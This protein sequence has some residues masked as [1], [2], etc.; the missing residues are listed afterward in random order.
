MEER[1]RC[2]E[3]MK[4]NKLIYTVGLPAS[5]KSTWAKEFCI[6]SGGQTKRVNK[7]LL[8]LMVDAEKWSSH[9][10]KFIVDIRDSI[11][12]DT[13]ASGYDIVIDDTNL[14]Q[15]HVDRFIELAEECGATL[16]RVDFTNVPI[17]TCIERD[18]KR[19]KSVGRDTIW[20]M[21]LRDIAK[22]HV[23]D[24]NLKECIIVD[25]D[26]TY[27]NYE[28]GGARA[29]ERDFINDTCNPLVNELVKREV[30]N[31]RKLVIFSGRS[32]KFRDET[33]CWLEK[34]N[35]KP[36]VFAMRSEGSTVKDTEIKKEMFDIHV[37]GVYNVVY[38]IDDRDQMVK[39]WKSLNIPVMWM[40][41][42]TVF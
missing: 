29:Y 5:G 20:N 24:N 33:E 4:K 40:G 13:L 18:E 38:C 8:R 11:I 42:G 14:K 6:N 9:R 27:C 17:H 35:I 12:K 36:D 10:E 41:D 21:Y 19:A 30:R 22:K 37:D 2:V 15:K 16:E 34:H 25:L 39:L 7:D 26:G 31:G 1:K 32:D 28:G 23:H 3:N